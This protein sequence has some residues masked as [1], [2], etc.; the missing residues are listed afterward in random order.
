MSPSFLPQWIVTE[1]STKTLPPCVPSVFV[2]HYHC[3]FVYVV[4]SPWILSPAWNS[5]SFCWSWGNDCSRTIQDC[6]WSLLISPATWMTRSAR[7]T[8]PAWTQSA[9][10]HCPKMVL[11]QILLPVTPD[12][13]P[14]PPSPHCVE[15][16]PESTADREPEPAIAARSNR[17][18]DRRGAATTSA[19][20]LGVWAGYN[21]CH[22]G[23]SGR[24]ERGEELR[25]LHH[26]WGWAEYGFATVSHRPERATDPE[27][28]PEKSP[29]PEFRPESPEAHKWPPSQ[30]L[31]PPLP[32]SSSSPSTR[33]L[34]T[35]YVVQAP[36]DCHPPASP[37]SEYPL[38]PTP[39][40]KLQDP[41]RP[42]DPS[43][44][45]WLLAPSSPPWSICPLAQP[46]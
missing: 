11:E 4:F 12:P 1:D 31:L 26:S 41:H 38:T 36:R 9:K 13:V 8:M 21:A 17:A 7:S 10:N 25:P 6:S 43:A 40:S 15:R 22:K 35:I 2:S 32:L 23:E 20:S 46:G 42:L 18:P 45:P 33:P 37:C 24:C 29:I 28:S 5:S 16:I 39:A 44:P 19:V 34:L 30:P 27:L 3:V 14:S